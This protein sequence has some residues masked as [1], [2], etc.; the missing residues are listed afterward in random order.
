MFGAMALAMPAG[1]RSGMASA[2]WRGRAGGSGLARVIAIIGVS[3]PTFWLA[4]VLVL[5][6]AYLPADL[7]D[8]WVSWRRRGRPALVLPVLALAAAPAALIARITR[9]SML[10]RCRRT[11]SGRRGRRDCAGVRSIRRHALRNAINPVMTV[12]GFQFGNLIGG[13]VAIEQIFGLRASARFW[14]RRSPKRTWWSP[15]GRAGDLGR[16]HRIES[17]RSICCMR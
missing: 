6:F 1:C 14:S 17:R 7:S 12:I 2:M 4:L 13:A 3:T 15:K 10:E 16:V 5:L 9:S 11:P 8:A